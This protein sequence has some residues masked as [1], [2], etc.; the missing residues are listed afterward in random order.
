M[1]VLSCILAGITVGVAFKSLTLMTQPRSKASK[2]SHVAAPPARPQHAPQA[3]QPQA[4]LN[5]ADRLQQ[6]I[7]LSTLRLNGIRLRSNGDCSNRYR[8]G[9]TSL[10]GIRRGS[11]AGLLAFKQRSRCRITVSGGTERGHAPGRYSHWNG[12]KIDVL[13]N[14]CI[15]RYITKRF[16]Y[17]GLRGDGAELYRSPS[18]GV[19]ANEGSHWDLLYR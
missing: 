13:P 10:Q 2:R 19:Y 18:G 16:K 4:M 11:I 14:R 6:Q 5:K 3:P 7:A 17:L 12:Y 8:L 1:W 9:C 15:D